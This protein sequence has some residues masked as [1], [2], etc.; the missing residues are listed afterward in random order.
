MNVFVDRSSF[1]SI[2]EL[3]GIV[4]EEA[5]KTGMNVKK[6]DK[7][8]SEQNKCIQI[9]DFIA[10]ATRSYHENGNDTLKILDEKISIARR[11]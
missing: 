6:C 2:G 4:N 3:R 11:Y 8:T 9:A 1:I 7:A 10:G 5:K